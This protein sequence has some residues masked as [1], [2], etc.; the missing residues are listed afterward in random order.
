MLLLLLLHHGFE[1]DK[2]FGGLGVEAEEHLF[3]ISFRY[4][5]RYQFGD[6]LTGFLTSK[7]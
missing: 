1:I 2:L 5:S 6:D 4:F 7:T 3:L